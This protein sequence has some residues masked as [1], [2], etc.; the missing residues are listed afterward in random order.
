MTPFDMFITTAVDL[1]RTDPA[2]RAELE[3][4]RETPTPDPPVAPSTWDRLDELDWLLR[5]GLP[6]WFAAMQVGWTVETAQDMAHRWGHPVHKRLLVEEAPGLSDWW[7]S[8]WLA[9]RA[10]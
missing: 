1:Y 6:D 9:G 4:E 10:A 3:Q 7:A 2:Y 5:N 8:E